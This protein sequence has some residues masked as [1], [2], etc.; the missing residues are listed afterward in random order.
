[1]LAFYLEKTS[2][3]SVPS[4]QDAK[5]V[6]ETEARSGL[7]EEKD[8]KLLATPELPEKVDLKFLKKETSVYC[9]HRLRSQ[10]Q[11]SFVHVSC[12]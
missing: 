12:K 2:M 1:M 7:Q 9:L 5:K 8:I 10:K 4:Q 6:R 11:V 3:Q